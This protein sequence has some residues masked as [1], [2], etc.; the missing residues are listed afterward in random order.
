MKIET[1]FFGEVEIEEKSII[2]FEKGIPGLEHLQK[3]IILDLEDN[4]NIKCL[5]SLEEA[6]ICLLITTPWTYFKDY[7]IQLS[8]E[9]IS[10]LD[11]ISEADASVYNVITVRGDKITANLMA[12]VVINVINNKGRQIILSESKYSIRQEISCL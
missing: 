6:S 8:D 11:L 12:P 2:T 4:Q 7:E 1:R 3:F 5:Q 9:E 10:E